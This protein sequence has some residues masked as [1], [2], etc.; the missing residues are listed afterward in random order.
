MALVATA[1]LLSIPGAKA[2]SPVDKD[3]LLKAMQA[4]MTEVRLGEMASLKGNRADVRELGHMIVR[5]DATFND[6]LKALAQQKGLPFPDALDAKHQA[7]VDKMVDLTGT[8]FDEAYIATMAKELADLARDFKSESAT[9]A[10]PEVKTVVDKSVLI[11][12]QHL[13]AISAMR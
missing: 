6:D 10:D 11:V 1:A 5:D 12:N 13:K 8:Q 3:F 4:G 9:T 7:M 2:A